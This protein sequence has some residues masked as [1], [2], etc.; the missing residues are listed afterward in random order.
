MKN[1]IILLLIVIYSCGKDSIPDPDPAVLLAPQN[2][3]NCNTASSVS[4]DQ[5]RVDF[6]WTKS[7][8][9]DYYEVIAINKSSNIKYKDTTSGISFKGEVSES[10]SLKLTLPKGFAYSWSVTSFSN[11]TII[12]TESEIWE[13]YLEGNVDG[14]FLPQPANLVYPANEDFISLENSDIIQFIWTSSDQDNNI[15]GY[16]FYLGTSVDS[17]VKIGDKISQNSFEHQL[18]P[19]ASYFWQIITFDQQGNYS[20]SGINQFQ[21]QP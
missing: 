16:D 21:T 6:S 14:D 15:L 10:I 12:M 18:Q 4:L 20:N 1:K 2:G 7:N 5:S 17:L 19:D 11:S 9:T 3:N 8:N 13:F